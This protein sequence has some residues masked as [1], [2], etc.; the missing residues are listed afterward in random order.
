VKSNSSSKYYQVQTMTFE[1]GSREFFCDCEAKE[2]GYAGRCCHILAVKEVLVAKAELMQAQGEEA[3]AEGEKIVAAQPVIAE[4][5]GVE[6]VEARLSD[7]AFTAQAVAAVKE[8]WHQK[9]EA[10]VAK[11]QAKEVTC[12]RSPAFADPTFTNR[13][14]YALTNNAGFSLFK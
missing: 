5:G 14:N 8:D 6:A 13:E 2:W 3:V 1:D 11:G 12:K 4:Q 7:A 10:K 9:F